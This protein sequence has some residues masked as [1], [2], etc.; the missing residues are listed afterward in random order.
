MAETG[1][2]RRANETTYLLVLETE[3]QNLLHDSQPGRPSA[4]F[5][6]CIFAFQIARV[7]RNLAASLER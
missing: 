5:A 7:V 2:K 4:L 1:Y 3:Q 6:V